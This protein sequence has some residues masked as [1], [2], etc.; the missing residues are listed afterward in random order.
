MISMA[1]ARPSLIQP[2]RGAQTRIEGDTLV[3]EVPADFLALAQL[4]ADEYRELAAK[5]GQRAARLRIEGG[6]MAAAAPPSPA[7]VKKQRL[8]NE[9]EREPAVK[10]ALDLFGGKIVDVREA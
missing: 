8:R 4:H 3:L 10:E 6:Q 9:A 2:L 1:Q 7:E 5:A